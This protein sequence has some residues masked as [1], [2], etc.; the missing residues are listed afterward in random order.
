MENRLTKQV[1]I[2]RILSQMEVW[3]ML[4]KRQ[5]P[6]RRI[7]GVFLALLLVWSGSASGQ[8]NTQGE[9]VPTMKAFYSSEAFEA[10]YTY[11]GHDLGATWA[12]EKTSFRVWAPTADAVTVQL[13]ASGAAG[14]DDLLERLPMQADVNGTW[15]A[16]KKG[17]LSGV[18]Y[19]YAVTL[20]GQVNEACDPYARATGVNGARAMVIDLA[21]TDPEGW[22]KDRNP[23]AGLSYN[24]AIIYELHVRDLSSD[25]SAG[26]KNAGKYL[27]LTEHGTV[28][29]GGVST[30]LDHIVD[31]GVTHVHLLPVY[32]FGSVDETRLDETQFNWGY[33]PVNLNVPEGSYATDPYN[34]EVRVKELKQMIQALHQS[35]VSV[36]MDVVYN[37]VYLAE[38]FCFNQ[39]VP[40]Y[41]SRIR[42]DGVYSNGSGCGNDTASERSMVRKY[43]VDSV[44]YWV[45]E[46]HMDGF[47]FDLVGL[48][49]TQTINEIVEEIH[50]DRPDVIFYGEGWTMGTAVTKPGVTMATQGNAPRTPGFAYFNDSLRNALRGTS[51]KGYASGA[52]GQD[53]AIRQ[54]F[55]GLNAWCTTPA[56]TINYASCHDN[57][58]LMDQITL[59]T[60][61]ATREERVRMNNLAAAIYLTAEGIPF[62]Q[63][64]E[65]MLRTKPNPDGSLN[66][67]SYNAPDAVNSL[68]WDTLEEAEYQQVYA[69]NK[70]LIAFRKAHGA[71]RLTTAEDVREHVTAINGLPYNVVAFQI[72]GGVDGEPADELFVIFNPTG[73]VQEIG[74]PEGTWHVCVNGERAGTESFETITDG[75]AVVAPISAMV[76]T[77]EQDTP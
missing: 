44:K 10:E 56:Q 11:P 14:E 64:G 72:D 27:G 15:V 4:Q 18:Y 13:Y 62:M 33:D 7:G 29:S 55:M 31:L 17:D 66:E 21:S 30:G 36:V 67:N 53:M 9:S 38:S 59:A 28:T 3:L 69:Y 6:L 75:T 58:T 48:L 76:L 35:G 61:N 5:P 51:S 71:L 32:D 46:Y 43:I 37:H 1:K 8:E 73:T 40:G 60:P 52:G 34:G 49:D 57:H 47:R 74:L 50:R 68:K 63:A 41:F 19:T 16:E 26:I 20:D 45:D 54:N 77:R 22:D 2:T 39:I 25:A 42:D 65:E 70:G 12:P 24:D 23:N